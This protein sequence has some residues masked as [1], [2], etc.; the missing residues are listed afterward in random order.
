MEW[1]GRDHN[2]ALAITELP[3]GSPLILVLLHISVATTIIPLASF[4]DI[5]PVLSVINLHT[6][7]NPTTTITSLSR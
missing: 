1:D 2:V 3:L 6:G 4:P 7:L 5:P